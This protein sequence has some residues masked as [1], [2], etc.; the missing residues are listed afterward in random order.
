MWKSLS[1]VAAILTAGGAFF[2]YKNIDQGKKEAQ[3]LDIAK[4]NLAKAE[5]QLKL[6]TGAV[7]ANVEGRKKADGEVTAIGKELDTLK[8]K[9]DELVKDAAE[10]KSELDEATQRWTEVTKQV[11]DLGGIEKLRV[12]LQA[13]MEKKSAL[14]GQVAAVKL[15][16][17]SATQSV[18]S[19]N[20]QIATL[21]VKEGWQAKGII[22]EGFRASI[23]Q[24]DPTWGFL[25][26]N[27]GNG[28]GVVSGATLDIRRG[29][30]VIGQAKVTNVEPNRSVA[31]FI[32]VGGSSAADV[33]VGDTV[34]VSAA[35]SSRTYRPPTPAASPRPAT[36]GGAAPAAVPADGESV[37]V[38]PDS[39]TVDPFA[40]PAPAAD[41][42]AP[43][44]PEPPADA[45]TEQPADPFTN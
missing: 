43:A 35:S 22:Q 42:F 2:T 4:D 14:D 16:A 24:I 18:S 27:A 29:G 10:K 44:A 28:S 6:A 33:Q 9:I 21:K 12:D 19:L 40:D 39:G 13:M 8:A 34:S 25:I 3:L 31:D 15:Q 38:P 26:I 5:Q 7:A 45:P 20:N 41:P 30:S 1:I 36:T 23:V 32:S 37:P 11:E 17:A